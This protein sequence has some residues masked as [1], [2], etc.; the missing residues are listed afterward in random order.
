L[1]QSLSEY[2]C[3]KAMMIVGFF[4]WLHVCCHFVKVAQIFVNWLNIKN[5]FENLFTWKMKVKIGLFQNKF[6]FPLTLNVHIFSIESKV[7]L[8]IIKC[9]PIKCKFIKMHYQMLWV[10]LFDI[11]DYLVRAIE[12]G[13]L[14]ILPWRIWHI[15]AK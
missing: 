8:V 6:F 12:K 4:F 3:T 15:N 13:S 5:H 14:S 7:V 10:L 11:C 2:V 9:I 1:N